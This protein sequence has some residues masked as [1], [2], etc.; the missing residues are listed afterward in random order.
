MRTMS[1]TDE[2]SIK[3][4]LDFTRDGFVSAF[5]FNVFIRWF[6]P[7]QGCFIRCLD[8]LHAGLVCGFVPA[9]EAMLLLKNKPM[10]T[11]LVRMSKTQGTR[12]SVRT[13]TGD[14]ERT[15]T[16][17]STMMT[18]MALSCFVL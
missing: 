4:F 13:G 1:A 8:A 5:E 7:Y 10:G 15:T 3:E 14:G 12:V 11:Y 18:T 6:G 2:E 17:T 16:L 9:I